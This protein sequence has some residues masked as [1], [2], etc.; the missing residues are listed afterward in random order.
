MPKPYAVTFEPNTRIPLRDGTVTYADV[1]RPER[2]GFPALLQRTP[3]DKSSPQSRT[4]TLDAVQA[5][6]T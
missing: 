5:A 3:Y 6:T 1:F 4:G 2:E